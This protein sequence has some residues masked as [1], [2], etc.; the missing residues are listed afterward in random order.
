MDTFRM[1]VLESET[2]CNFIMTT[3]RR[4]FVRHMAEKFSNVPP[5]LGMPPLRIY[6]LDG[7]P[8]LGC[9]RQG[10]W[11]AGWMTKTRSQLIEELKTLR[12]RVAELERIEA[13]H[14]LIELA[15]RIV[16][17][18]TALFLM[19]CRWRFIAPRRWVNFWMPTPQ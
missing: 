15:L 14:D 10:E 5:V 16:K 4:D 1:L 13:S 17:R 7:S 2:C 9:G 12:V 8:R 3:A 19:M 18:D 11:R 6:E